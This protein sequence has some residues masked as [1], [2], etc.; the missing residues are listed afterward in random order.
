MQCKYNYLY[1]YNMKHGTSADEDESDKTRDGNTLDKQRHG[2]FVYG[3]IAI[4]FVEILWQ[5]VNESC[6]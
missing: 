6:V 3:A 5:A 2:D 4:Y 1:D